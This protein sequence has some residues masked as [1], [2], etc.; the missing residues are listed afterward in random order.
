LVP[1]MLWHGPGLAAIEADLGERKSTESW[2]F[3][4]VTVD[5]SL[6]Q[7]GHN[8]NQSHRLAIDQCHG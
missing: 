7:G 1:A 5:Q 8:V 6:R 4:T 3:D 2:Q